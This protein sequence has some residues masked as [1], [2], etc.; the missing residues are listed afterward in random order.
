MHISGTHHIALVTRDLPRLQAFYVETLGLPL[1]GEF[2][3]RDIVFVGIGE[4]AIE[5]IQRPDATPAAGGL[6]WAHLAPEVPDVDAAVSGLTAQGIHF[7][8]A[9]MDFPPDSPDVRI[10]FCRDPDGNEIELVQRFGERYPPLRDR[11]GAV[12]A[13]AD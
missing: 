7:H 8:V 3:G 9:P 10:A 5:L 4:T 2:A 1:V 6:G 13:L 12:S 11:D